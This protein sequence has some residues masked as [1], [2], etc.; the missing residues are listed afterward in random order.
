MG[1]LNLGQ[2]LPL[3]QNRKQELSKDLLALDLQLEE[4]GLGTTSFGDEVPK[5]QRE[6]H[7]LSKERDHLMLALSK[8]EG[9]EELRTRF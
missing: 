1:A 8:E 3:F 4:L 7:Q 6:L 9:P 5:L 2:Q